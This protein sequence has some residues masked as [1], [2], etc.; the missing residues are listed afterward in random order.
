MMMENYDKSAEI[1][2]NPNCLYISDYTSNMHSNQSINC[3]LT[4][5]KSR[6]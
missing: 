3:S 2:H 5:E 1:N 4:G 6:D